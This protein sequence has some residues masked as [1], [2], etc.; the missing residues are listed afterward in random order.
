MAD[1]KEKKAPPYWKIVSYADTDFERGKAKFEQMC[2]EYEAAKTVLERQ[3]SMTIKNHQS[4]VFTMAFCC[5][6]E[7]ET[8]TLTYPLSG[9]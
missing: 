9:Y 2:N 1:E 3:Y 8:E 7:D 6:A 5:E 4:Y